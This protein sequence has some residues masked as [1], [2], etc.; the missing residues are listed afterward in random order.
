MGLKA[1]RVRSTGFVS[2]TSVKGRITDE[3]GLW[4]VFISIREMLKLLNQDCITYGTKLTDK[5]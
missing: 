5:R 3:N 1:E 2:A 4:V